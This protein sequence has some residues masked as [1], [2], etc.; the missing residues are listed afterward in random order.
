MGIEVGK[1]KVVI[2]DFA[3][4]DPSVVAEFN[5]AVEQGRSPSDFMESLLSLGATVIALGSNTASAEKIDASVDQARTSIREAAEGF[6]EVIEKQVVAFSSED[7]TLVKGFTSALDKLKREIDELA[8]GEDSPLRNA[9]LKSLEELKE[10]MLRE[11]KD[12]IADQKR[13]L[14]AMMDP[15][16]PQSPLKSINQRLDQVSSAVQEVHLEVAKEIALA[17]MAEITPVGGLAYEEVAVDFV[18]K[19]ASWAGDDCEHTGNVT[20]AVPRSK[21]GDGVVDLKVGATV[22]GRMVIEA[23]NS[24]LSK[25]EWEAECEGSRKNRVADGFIGL[26]KHEEDMPT[27]SRLMILDA[28]AVVVAFDPE[29]DDGEL[30]HLVYQLVKMN[31]LAGS[32][33]LDEVSIID[34]RQNLDGAAKALERFEKLTKDATAIENSVKSI[35]ANASEIRGIMAQRFSAIYDALAFDVAV[36]EVEEIDE[37]A[38]ELVIGELGIGDDDFEVGPI[39]LVGLNDFEPEEKEQPN[40]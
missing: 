14:V 19:L 13:D 15:T 21:K 22:A 3:T 6:E 26:C 32:G 38:S 35:K 11:M 28:S 36:P 25:R 2:N 1:R 7:G 29:E 8:A 39:D 27:S 34:V 37:V 5:H 20:G 31:T 16:N 18:Q 40:S 30:L 9:V 10:K 23:K 24:Q 33:Q 17:E 12:Q 4:E